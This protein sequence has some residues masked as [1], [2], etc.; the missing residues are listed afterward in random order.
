MNLAKLARPYWRRY[1]QIGIADPGLAQGQ[2]LGRSV[3]FHRPRT[4]S[5]TL[6]EKKPHYG[7]GSWSAV[8]RECGTRKTQHW[9]WD[10]VPFMTIHINSNTGFL[11][12]TVVL[13]HIKQATLAPIAHAPA[14]PPR[15][16]LAAALFMIS[17]NVGGASFV[18]GALI[19]QIF[20]G[21]MNGRW[22]FAP[23][24]RSSD[25]YEVCRWE[26]AALFDSI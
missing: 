13:I 22:M 12:L 14:V 25:A 4:R 10:P 7:T 18:V 16:A 20:L 1:P 24:L 3:G 26:T 2:R 21:E 15:T 8:T 23:P 19:V 9:W 6:L 11:A 5:A 17:W